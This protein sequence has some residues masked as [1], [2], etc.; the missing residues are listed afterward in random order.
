MKAD[1]A[2]YPPL[3][4]PKPVAD[5]VWI[6][7]SSP[8]NLIG[9]PLPIRMTVLRLSSGALLLHSPTRFHFPLK[10]ELEKLGS[11]EHLVAPNSAHWT[12]LQEWQAHLPAVRTWAAP[13]LRERAQVRRSGVRLDQDLGSVAPD[14][15]SQEIEQVVVPGGGGFA[16]VALFH[17]SS[18]TL[19][20]T[21]LVV[22]LEPA[23]VPLIFRPAAYLLG[24]TAPDGKA[25]VY[26]RA[27]IKRKGQQA[28]DAARKLVELEPERVI[29]AHG[30]WFQQ[31]ATARLRKSLAWLL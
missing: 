20:L 14:A 21:D 17:K 13:G 27:V 15:W 26:L 30:Q 19:V 12:F 5:G 16:E 28:S 22:N 18:R 7:D 3:D 10:D 31:D 1:A 11:I 9:L 2:A 25:P 23:K 29:F 6:V 24:S 4:I 8:L